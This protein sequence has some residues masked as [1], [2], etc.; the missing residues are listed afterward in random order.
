MSTLF[1]R[2]IAQSYTELLKTASN[3]GVTSSLTIVEDG[4]AT[5]SAL[6]IS[7]TT[8]KSSGSLEV[9]G[10]TTLASTL[11]VTGI[12][13]LTGNVSMGGDL[14]VAGNAV[15][16]GTLTANGGTLT[17]GDADTDNVVFN[18][19]INSHIL[20]NTDNTY[21]LGSASKSW[22]NLHIDGTATINSLSIT[23]PLTVSATTQSTDKDTG[24]LVVEG[25]VGVE[26]N[27]NVGGNLAV[28]GVTNLTGNVTLS[29]ELT[30]SSS[31]MNIGNGQIY[32]SATGD[33]YFGA[34]SK[35]VSA[36]QAKYYFVGDIATVSN[37]PY[38]S[39]I[40]L[41]ASNSSGGP[42][43]IFQKSRGTYSS[44]TAVSSADLLGNCYW[45]GHDGAAY[46]QGAG[47]A[48]LVDGAVSTGVV[49][50]AL[51]VNT[52]S[53]WNTT[54][55]IRITSGGN[56]GISEPNPSHKLHVNGTLGVT[57]A[58]TLS[59]TLGVSNTISATLAS[60]TGLA[61]TANATIGGTLGVTGNSN[62]GTIAAGTWQGTII[63]P[64]YGGTGVNNGSKTIT[65]GGNLTTSGA[66]ATTLASTANTNV[67]LPTT[68]TLATL[69]NTETLTNKTL[70]SPTLTTP[71]LG[72]PAS[73]TLANC[74]DLPVSTGI[75]GLAANVAT[76]LATPSSANF[77]AA[78]TDETGSG[79]LVF[80]TS[81]TLVTPTLGTASATSINKVA[82][83]APLNSS[84]LTIADGKTLTASNTLTFSGT[85]TSSVA[86]GSGGTVAY[87]AN[88]LSA[89]ASTTSSELAGVISDETG[90]GS[91]V[92]ANSPTLVTPTLGAA[93]ATSLSLGTPLSPANG[94]TGLSTT[95]AAAAGKILGVAPNGSTHEY[96][97]LTP[98][99][100]ISITDAAGIVTITNTGSGSGGG[101]GGSASGA[102]AIYR[103]NATAAQT[104][105]SGVD[106]STPP[107][108]L[109]YTPNYL[110]VFLNGVKLDDSDF[111]ATNGTS[112]TLSTACV[113]NDD[114]D[115]VAFGS[116]PQLASPGLAN[117]VVGT[118]AGGTA[119]EYKQIVAGTG[120]SIA[121]GVGSLTISA[122]GSP[123]SA[124]LATFRYIASSNQ[125]VFT[126]VDTGGNQ[127]EFTPGFLYVFVN[128]VLL[129]PSLDYTT[130]STTTITLTSGCSLS[131]FVDILAFGQVNAFGLVDGSVTTA[132]LNLL[133]GNVG[134]GTNNPSTPSGKCLTIYDSSIPRLNL[135]NS[136]SGD[137]STDGVELSLIGSDAYLNNREN[138]TVSIATN[139][140]T[141]LLVDSSGNVGIG[142]T[143]PISSLHIKHATPTSKITLEDSSTNRVGQIAG[144]SDGDGGILTFSVGN[145][146]GTITERLR[147]TSGGFM[148]ASDDSSYLSLA[149]GFHELRNS[150]SNEMLVGTN[151]NAVPYGIQ[152]RYTVSPNNTTSA[153]LACLDGNGTVNRATIRS[154]G[155]LANFSANN[156]NLSDE[157]LKESIQPSPSYLNKICS[158]P[159]VNYKYKDQT[160]DDYNLGVI[161]Q[162]VEAV[163]PELVDVDGFGETPNDG[164]P[165]KSIY[166]TD[167]QYAL[168]KCI[169]ELKAENDSLKSRIETLEAA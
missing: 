88:K 157:R 136:T 108:T 21:D 47:V 38:G 97:T 144:G 109:V 53:G 164:I 76:F 13:T 159:I 63:N 46:I 127:L 37:S 86:F 2:T 116:V 10:S 32:K 54:E 81:P 14:T 145:N 104:V 142:T 71:T 27:V 118:T 98:G 162:Q 121:Q 163:C 160:H 45:G 111:T 110:S 66:F 150:T 137:T 102:V 106:T 138:G 146:G 9:V 143:S 64:T 5:A 22:R 154:N 92:F 156:V 51:Q 60:G 12:S 72:T 96:K 129:A 16:Q 29:G 100:G 112:V 35:P 113:L 61:V 34:T 48:A 107:T 95:S 68:G 120:V 87:T 93:S 125:T 117:Y 31:L 55:R 166:Q 82:I 77:A 151:T 124:P 153:Y 158:I 133:T 52:G 139:N 8:V 83:T 131:D 42:Y 75:S 165:L 135:K 62:L 90:T 148:K 103:Y 78:V 65:L 114:V 24:A 126:G 123:L 43:V 15:I 101:G 4:D 40:Q 25:G 140:A 11:S 119:L 152:L 74:T 91:L 168:M 105:F 39:Q 33:V 155:G 80:A 30:G 70:T 169:Q 44:P 6:Q 141:R 122:G 3:S 18:A 73:G 149:G 1:D 128:G 67:T 132:K 26:K 69:A 161:A 57:G 36:T 167:L 50:T 41:F 130:T 28:T 17:L 79:S 7:T 56:V 59:S 58:A 89:F 85:D 99:T 147:I 20:P 115:I 23:S 94:G 84:T 19:D 134:I 49:P